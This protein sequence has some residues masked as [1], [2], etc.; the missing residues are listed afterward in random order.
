MS[1]R[2]FRLVLAGV[3]FATLF[4]R[5]NP[6]SDTQ[7]MPNWVFILG[8]SMEALTWLFSRPRS[9]NYSVGFAGWL[10][11][12]SLLS[13]LSVPFLISLNVLL[14][15]CPFRG[16][17][18]WLKML[19]RISVLILLSLTWYLTFHIDPGWRGVGFWANTAVVSVAALMEI[20][21]LISGRLRKRQST[22]PAVE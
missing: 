4:L 15:V 11:F 16:L 8:A 17:N 13:L 22:G 6:L 10:N 5:W 19:C 20:V 7:G 1:E 2:L 9:V 18:R 12:L 14:A 3:M 21:F